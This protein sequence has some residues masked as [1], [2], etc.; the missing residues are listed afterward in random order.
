MLEMVGTASEM[1]VTTLLLA[2]A[3]LPL[4]LNWTSRVA[5]SCLRRVLLAA[6]PSVHSSALLETLMGSH[7]VPLKE[8]TLLRRLG[9]KP[10]PLTVTVLTMLRFR[11]EGVT[12]EISS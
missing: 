8:S 11:L 5:K 7:G 1:E 4:K 2:D 10:A 9:L 6:G 3:V 12:P